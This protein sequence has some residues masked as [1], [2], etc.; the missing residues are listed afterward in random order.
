MLAEPITS[1]RRLQTV[2]RKLLGTV[3]DLSGKG[4]S[5]GNQDAGVAANAFG[6]G[7]NTGVGG[8]STHI[9]VWLCGLWAHVQAPATQ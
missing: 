2:P 4:V 8:T 7:T 1:G 3:L 9:E 6:H 5:A